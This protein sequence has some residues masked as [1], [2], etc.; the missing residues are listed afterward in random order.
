MNG[1]ITRPLNPQSFSRT[2]YGY[3][4]NRKWLE[5]EKA[6]I[7]KSTGK[8]LEIKISNDPTT[9]GWWYLAYKII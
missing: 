7:E 5:K 1:E 9:S 8:E 3:I 2:M 4:T 6:R